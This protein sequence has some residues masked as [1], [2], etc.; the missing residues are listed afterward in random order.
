MESAYDG[1]GLAKGGAISLYVDGEKVGEGRIDASVPM[2]FSGDET[3]DLGA[4]TASPAAD[5]YTT[6]GGRFNGRVKWVQ[7]DLDEAA[8]DL[9]HLISVEERLKI[10]MARQ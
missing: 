1:G 2:M 8:E 7:I 10:A 5:D 9:D 6:E 3:C 4:G